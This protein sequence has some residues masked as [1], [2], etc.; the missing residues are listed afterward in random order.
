MICVVASK[1]HKFEDVGNSLR[2]N[3]RKETELNITKIC[4]QEQLQQKFDDQNRS[5]D[6]QELHAK[7]TNYTLDL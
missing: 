7:D 1:P 3:M 4:L 6:Y 2:R 5:K